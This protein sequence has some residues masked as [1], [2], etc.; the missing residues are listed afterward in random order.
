MYVRYYVSFVLVIYCLFRSPTIPFSITSTP[1]WNRYLFRAEPARVV[2]S[3][4]YPPPP[5]RLQ[6]TSIGH[7]LGFLNFPPI[8]TVKCT[9]NQRTPPRSVLR[10]NS[11]VL[12]VIAVF[13]R[14]RVFS[15][16]WIVFCESYFVDCYR[17]TRTV[18]TVS[19]HS[20]RRQNFA[21][22]AIYF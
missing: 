6:W 19:F 2:H 10:R 8:S 13:C 20:Q 4:E 7:Q 18:Q 16:F 9:C 12:E 3:R 21:T 11:S 15:A 17:S 5:P 22:Q 14:K 1:A